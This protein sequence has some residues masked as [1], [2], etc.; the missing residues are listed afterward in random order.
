MTNTARAGGRPKTKLT[1]EQIKQVEQLAPLLNQEQLCDFLGIPSRTFREILNRDEQVSAAY[2][3]GAAQA[4]GTVAQ[5]LIRQATDGNV[6]AQIFFLKTRA[7]WREQAPEASEA[8][9]ININLVK[10]VADD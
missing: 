10:P 6:T 1:D 9:P 5:A 7:G 8:Q 3:K 4:I 2:K